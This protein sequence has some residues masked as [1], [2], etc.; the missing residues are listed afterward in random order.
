GFGVADDEA[1]LARL[2][3]E[4]TA[5]QREITA[6][7]REEQYAGAFAGAPADI[8]FTRGAPVAE[9]PA[10]ATEDLDKRIAKTK[11]LTAAEKAHN[12]LMEEIATHDQ[13]ATEAGHD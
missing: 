3:R 5:I 1:V 12:Q 2:D 13:V 4:A 10:R 8:D 6:R 7:I 11:E 9:K